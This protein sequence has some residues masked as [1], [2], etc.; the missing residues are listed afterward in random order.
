MRP[1]LAAREGDRSARAA[2]NVEALLERARPYGVKASSGSSATS[3]RTGETARIVQRRPRRR[4]RR[5]HR[6]HHHPQRQGP[7]MAGGDP[8]QHRHL[9]PLAR[10]VRASRAD[11]TLHWV[12]GDVVPP[13]LLSALAV[14]RRKPRARAGTPL[15]RRLHPRP[16]AANRPRAPAGGTE[17]LGAD[18][19]SRASGPSAARPF[20][21]PSGA[22]FCGGRYPPNRQT[23][24]I[25]QA[26]GEVIAA[27]AVPL[28]WLRP[29]APIQ[30]HLWAHDPKFE[31]DSIAGRWAFSLK[32][33]R[34]NTGS[35]LARREII[36][37]VSAE[38]TKDSGIS[39]G[40]RK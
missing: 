2:A 6:D 9:A 32:E 3:P 29:H 15:V 7:G 11:D 37:T 20:A 1:I 23:A 10:T 8:D 31:F 38:W 22:A 12:I 34:P 39:T 17:I 13:D 40:R 16:R 36:A 21:L 4:R 19:R 25:F 26:E 33:K 30:T 18:R 27:A 35:P 28:L 24:E 5:C 14:R